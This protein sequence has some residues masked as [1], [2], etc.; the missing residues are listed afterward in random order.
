MYV[1]ASSTIFVMTIASC[2]V[3]AAKH[4]KP[5]DKEYSSCRMV[6][7]LGIKSV[8]MSARYHM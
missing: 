4:I 3:V 6:E 5:S 1:P 2:V 8:K 7:G